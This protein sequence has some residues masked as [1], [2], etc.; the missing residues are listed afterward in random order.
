MKSIRF[1]LAVIAICGIAAVV[2][3]IQAVIWE[4]QVEA[5]R[6]A[7]E[8]ISGQLFQLRTVMDAVVDTETGQ[9]GYLLTGEDEYL[10]P[11][12]SGRQNLDIGLG[13]LKEMSRADPAILSN[14]A[15]LEDNVRAKEAELARTVQLREGGDSAGALATVKTG[16]GRRLMVAFR[17]NGIALASRL[18]AARTANGVAE[19]RIFRRATVLGGVL[20]FLILTLVAVAIRWLSV[21]LHRVEEMQLQREEEA[22]HDA[23]TTLPNRRYLREWVAMA[24]AAADRGGHR[25][26]LLY[27]DLD[28]FKAV[29]DRLGHEAGDRVLQTI[30]E[31]VRATVRSSDFVARLGGDEFV[32]VLPDAPAEPELSVLVARLH[33]SL[34][35]APIAELADGEVSA[36][37]GLARHPE[38]GESLAALLNV[39]DRAMYTAKQRRRPGL[40]P[41]VTDGPAAAR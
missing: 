13:R 22:M 17:E 15:E 10:Q 12:R 39:A 5:L 29:N 26:V 6:D 9:R 18:R 21:S 4:T 40:A 3:A 34:A 14:I 41:A 35:K 20:L 31:R 37:I 2:A 33:A 11:Y 30:A 19:T 8:A 1:G 23:L 24:L 7:Q 27:F 16:E 32:A 28:G 38:D 25:L 36:S